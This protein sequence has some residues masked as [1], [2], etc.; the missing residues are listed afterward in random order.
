MRPSILS[1]A[2]LL[3]LT[4][5]PPAFALTINH[6]AGMN[7]DGTAKFA[8]P[9]E[10]MPNFMTSPTAPLAPSG[11]SAVQSPSGV[12]LPVAPGANMGLSVNRIGPA[13]QP[14]AFDQ[15]Y[16]RK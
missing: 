7:S 16:D 5:S 8:D 13:P 3:T 9:D 1:L 11:P 6:E 4:L 10:Q 15:A 12:M 14:D 2:A